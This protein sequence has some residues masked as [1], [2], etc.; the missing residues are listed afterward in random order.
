M[1]DEK[2]KERKEKQEKAKLLDEPFKVQDLIYMSILSF[3]GKAWAYLDLVPHPETEKHHKDTEQAKLAIDAID[4]LFKIV[5][6]KLSPEQ[7]KDLQ[8]RLTN[9]RLNFAKK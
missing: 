1:P 4:N 5:E 9:L 2:N 3:E 6:N 8:V 7:K